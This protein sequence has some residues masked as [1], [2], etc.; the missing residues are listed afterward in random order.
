MHRKGS[1][2]PR[3]F[4]LQ[5]VQALLLALLLFAGC[6]TP[7]ETKTANTN[8]PQSQ[9]A[10]PTPTQASASTSPAP[11]A[12]ASSPSSGPALATADGD[13]PGVRVEVQELKRSSGDTLTLRF[14]MI[15]DSDTAMGFG[16]D[17]GDKDQ[18]AKDYSAIGG[19]HLIDA[20]GKKKYFVTRD[21][22]NN[23]VCSRDVPNIAP[24]SRANL[25]AKFPAP[26][27]DVQRIT[28][29]IPHFIPMDDVPISR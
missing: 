17:F 7:E 4:T 15:N 23:C 9:A 11:P 12:G 29:V 25:W 27:E 8:A 18:G 2:I 6:N 24:Q 10:T 21:T 1:L 16:Y 3:I 13:K 26:P 20:V 5:G 19:V 22:E 14:V 28:V